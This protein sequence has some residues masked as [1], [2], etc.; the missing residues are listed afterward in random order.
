MKLE[1]TTSGGEQLI[2]R[3][4]SDGRQVA[5]VLLHKLKTNGGVLAQADFIVVFRDEMQ[6]KREKDRRR[7]KNGII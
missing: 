7:M 2:Q 1:S 5:H 3:L 4:P 6:E